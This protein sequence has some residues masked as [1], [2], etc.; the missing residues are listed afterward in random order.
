MKQTIRIHDPWL[1]AF[2]LAATCLGLMFIFDAGYAR[3]LQSERG[4]LP[5]EFKSQLIFLV[6]SAIGTCV[7]T[8]VPTKQWKKWSKLAWIINLVLLVAV[9][10]VGHRLNGAKRWIGVGTYSIQPAEFAKLAAVLY[11][12]GYFA[13]R[14]PWKNVGRQKN[15]VLTVDNIWIPKL[16]RALPALWVL[17]GVFLIEVEPDLGTGAVIAATG[18]AMFLPGGVSKKSMFLAVLVA[19]VAGGIG[20]A[21]QPYRIER[22]IDHPHR[23]TSENIDDTEYQTVQSELA[24]SSG[25][26]FGVGL[27]A[28]RAKEVLPATTT[29]FV[30]ATVGEESGLLGSFA[31]LGVL[32]ALVFRLFQLASR[33]KDRFDMLVLYGVGCWLGV[34]TC[35]NVMMANAFLPAIGIPLPFISSGGS[36]LVALWLAIGVCQATQAPKPVEQEEG[37][38]AKTEKPKVRRVHGADRVPVLT[39]NLRGRGH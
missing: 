9:L 8:R 23:W 39:T 30:W 19:L 38:V 16:M 34:Q 13:E 32:G 6:F 26:L 35:V 18:F 3:A 12:A 33:T 24:I 15:F 31:V 7:A 37:Q 17:L 4:G 27:G 2:A 20:V 29:D 11:L 14:K 25:G 22:F 36:S 21:K 5:S 28:G 10:L 1:F